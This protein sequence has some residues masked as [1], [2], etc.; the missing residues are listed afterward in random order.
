MFERSISSEDI[1]HIMSHGENIGD[2]PDDTPYP[3]RLI[4]GFVRNRPLHVVAAFHAMERICYIITVYEPDREK[5]ADDFRHRRQ[6]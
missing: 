6:A 3:S 4:L 1:R 2:Y 5:W